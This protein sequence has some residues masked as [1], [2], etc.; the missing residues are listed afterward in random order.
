MIKTLLGI[1]LWFSVIACSKA[2]VLQTY[3]LDSIHINAT[4]VKQYRHK[5]VKVSYP[6]S[7]R[8]EI[9]HRM[10]FSYSIND[11]GTYLNSEWSNEMSKLLQVTL[12]ESLEQSKLFKAVLSDTS[13]LR[14]NYRL[15]S[16]VFAFEHRVRGKQSH[17]IVSIQF[18]LIDADTGGLIKQKR[19]SYKEPTPSSNAKG[20]AYATNNAIKKLMLDLMRWLGTRG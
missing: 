10:N 16:Q 1:L 20:Y 12:I 8:E 11:R 4:K 3:T 13:T 14:E 2:P 7:L 18:T 17:A 15:E 5:I 6:Q 19:F 9:T